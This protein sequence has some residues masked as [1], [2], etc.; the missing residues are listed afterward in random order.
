MKKVVSILLIILLL[1]SITCTNFVL[2]TDDIEAI[3]G[4]MQ[5]V[6]NAQGLAATSSTASL[7]NTVIGII[8]IVGTGISLIVISLLG[9]KY[10][11]ASPGEKADVKK[12]IM[13]VLIGCILLFAAVNIVGVIES[14]TNE[15]LPATSTSP[16]P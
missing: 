15:T 1:S 12:S 2:A 9:I 8:Q 16:A 6:G 13:P 3:K 10:I 14:F 5:Q 4:A 11:L 7:I